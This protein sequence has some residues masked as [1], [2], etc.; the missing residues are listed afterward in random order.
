MNLDLLKLLLTDFNYDINTPPVASLTAPFVVILSKLEWTVLNNKLLDY[1]LKLNNVDLELRVSTYE[2]MVTPPEYATQDGN[3]EAATKMIEAGAMLINVQ[4]RHVRSSQFTGL[5]KAIAFAGLNCLD[6][7]EFQPIE[8]FPS[9]YSHI[10][11]ELDLV[12]SWIEKVPKRRRTLMELT[13]IKL[14]EQLTSTQFR[15]AIG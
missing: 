13:T 9:K 15:Q 10:T 12:Q 6:F 5:V 8:K 3:F 1:V 7:L 4:K 2:K 11:S 14:R